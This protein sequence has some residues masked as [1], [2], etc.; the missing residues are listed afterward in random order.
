MVKHENKDII[1]MYTDITENITSNNLVQEDEDLSKIIEH[2]KKS[3]DP[4]KK[5]GKDMKKADPFKDIEK[6]FKDVDKFFK[7]V[8]QA[9]TFSQKKMIAVISTIVIPF[10]GQIIGRFIYLDGSLDKPWL[11]LFGIPPLTLIP[12]LMMMFGLIKKGKGGK[13]WDY[14]ILIPII[15]NI[16]MGFVLKKYGIK[17][18]IIKYVVLL[19][20][21]F[22][23]YWLRSKK[24]CKN[25]SAR[26]TKILTDSLITYILMEVMKIVLEYVPLI[27]IMIKVIDKTIPYGY[28]ILDAFSIFC[29][30]IITNMINSSSSNFCKT[31]TKN[32]YIGI[33]ILISIMITYKNYLSLKKNNNIETNNDVNK[34]IEVDKKIISV[35]KNIEVDKIISVDK[36]IEVDK[37]I[38]ADKNITIEPNNDLIKNIEIDKNISV[39]KNINIEKNS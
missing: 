17:G 23:I 39:D 30:Y 16:I 4:F 15:L 5:M 1:E 10:I 19:L 22:F 12:A 33:L 31:T 18:Q 6:F 8:K 13:P 37:I 21:F 25:K 20:S 11:L 28:L 24:L 29:V 36:N 32:K 9:F 38:S 2:F 35:D 34:N 14:Y 27:G 26:F 7:K 3:S